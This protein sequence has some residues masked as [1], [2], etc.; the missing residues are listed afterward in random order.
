[1]A[2]VRWV[3]LDVDYFTNPKALA[4][5]PGGRGLHLASI[6]WAGSQLTDGHVPEAAVPLI[7]HA[8]GTNRRAVSAVVDAG[9]WIPNG[10]G[11]I[12]HDFVEMNGSK[13]DVEAERERWREKQRRARARRNST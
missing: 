6:C 8:A 2:G 9:L 10:D 7:L 11:F 5:G 1:M 13:A 3:R 4:A 12:L